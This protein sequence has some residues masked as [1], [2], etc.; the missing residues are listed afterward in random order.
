[1]PTWTYWGTPVL[2][3]ANSTRSVVAELAKRAERIG[4]SNT[5]RCADGIRRT[6]DPILPNAAARLR[7]N[8]QQE[9]G[10][11]ALA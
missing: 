9:K 7:G 8:P 11:Q 2:G 1:M 6:S 5:E 3:H 10:R 4:C